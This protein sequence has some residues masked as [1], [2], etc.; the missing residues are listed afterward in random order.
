MKNK[1][2]EALEMI[3]RNAEMIIVG[4]P[5]Y[6]LVLIAREALATP[7]NCDECTDRKKCRFHR[8]RGCGARKQKFCNCQPTKKEYCVEYKPCLFH[9]LEPDMGMAQPMEY[10][11]TNE[12][13]NKEVEEVHTGE[14][15]VT[16]YKSGGLDWGD[17]E[18]KKEYKPVWAAIYQ[19]R[20]SHLGLSPRQALK[21]GIV[22]LEAIEQAESLASNAATKTERELGHKNMIRAIE[23]FLSKVDNPF[24]VVKD[25]DNYLK[26]GKAIQGKWHDKVSIATAIE[27]NE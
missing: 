16:D 22:A 12:P 7:E 23:L 14:V 5:G 19:K 20:I 27:S 11:T 8:C 24:D 13:T 3:D 18:L 1:L 2:R 9:P 21:V 25:T 26:F 10:V 17:K 4:E 15:R 6:S